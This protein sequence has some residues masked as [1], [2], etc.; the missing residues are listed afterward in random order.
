MPARRTALAFGS[1]LSG[2]KYPPL[3]PATRDC[4][5][6]NETMNAPSYFP[7]QNALY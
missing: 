7:A 2:Y 5:K 3:A 6:S 4:Q 1:G